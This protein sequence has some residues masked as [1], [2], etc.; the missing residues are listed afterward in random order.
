MSI[1]ADALAFAGIGLCSY[2]FDGTILSIDPVVLQ[3]FELED[4]FPNPEEAAGRNISELIVHTAPGG[5]LRSR[6]R[7]CGE[8]RGFEYPFRTIKGND[9]WMLRDAYLVQD[10]ETGEEVIQAVVQD[11]TARKHA[12]AALRTAK[13]FLEGVRDAVLLVDPDTGITLDANARM[14]EVLGYRR[15]EFVGYRLTD[16][17][18]DA[19]GH[20]PADLEERLADPSPQRLEWRLRSRNQGTLWVEIAL[21]RVE[22]EEGQRYVLASIRDIESRKAFER[23]LLRIREA[24]DDCGAAVVM[25]DTRVRGT[26]INAA[27]GLMFGFT[28]DAAPEVHL[29]KVF[30]DSEQ[31]ESVLESILMG[32]SYE[33]EALLVNKDGQPFPAAL[34]GAPILDDMFDLCGIIFVIT[35]ITN[36]KQMEA[37]LIQSQNLRSIGQLAAG[38]A[39]EIN[40]PMQYVGDNTRFLNEGFESL[41]A[42]L[43]ASQALLQAMGRD[44][45]IAA[46]TARAKAAMNKAD[47][48]YL[49]EE[50]PAAI[51]QSLEGIGHV[52]EIVRAMRQFTHPGTGEKKQIDINQ[53]IENTITVARN[54]WKYVADVKTEFAHDLPLVPCLPGDLNQV[55][56]NLI[57]NAAHAIGDVVGDGSKGKGL[58][59]IST[60]REGAHAVIRVTDTGTGIPEEI[61]GQVFAPFFTTKDVGKGTGQGLAISHSV[62]VEKH[63]GA[64]TFETENGRGT[65][66]IIRLPL[67]DR[68]IPAALSSG[69]HA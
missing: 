16:L 41:L 65:T 40:T 59:T 45:D 13:L 66:F 54:E 68:E 46:L 47:V 25:V 34:R 20:T 49:A 44:E 57:V 24:L 1:R 9:K 8:V 11:I 48:D 22:A 15:E 17:C 3:L 60:K 64:L 26:Y 5:L 43:Q 67:E 42:A 6:L 63:G 33:G 32:G 52:S 61:R 10:P 27:F 37:Q 30:A 19:T 7:E 38:V 18:V 4:S 53:A 39:H 28:R 51:T 35:D 12:E 58:I 56:L 21:S 36:M 23:E 14:L 31:A 29:P 69:D 62:V 2:R 55:M 50:I